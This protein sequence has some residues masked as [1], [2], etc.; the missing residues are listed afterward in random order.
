[1]LYIKCQLLTSNNRM[2][3]WGK[4]HATSSAICSVISLDPEH[5][6]CNNFHCLPAQFSKSKSLTGKTT[7]MAQLYMES[8]IS[9][10]PSLAKTTRQPDSLYLPLNHVLRT[11]IRRDQA[12]WLICWT[13]QAS[14]PRTTF[15][16]GSL[17]RVDLSWKFHHWGG[18][19][20][21]FHVKQICCVNR[22]FKRIV[23]LTAGFSPTAD[24][25]YLTDKTL[26]E[27]QNSN[28]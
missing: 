17:C 7:T 3:P 22:S 24:Y 18:A 1:M 13:Y 6:L 2:Q 15:L 5:P 11:E 23:L 19:R 8:L 9:G 21:K 20:I 14:F 28:L 27:L 12:R 26:F 4:S 16:R 25:N 10:H